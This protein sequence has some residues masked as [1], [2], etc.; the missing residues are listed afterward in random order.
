MKN[1]ILKTK[2]VN[3]T[4][5]TLSDSRQKLNTQTNTKMASNKLTMFLAW[6]V[7]EIMCLCGEPATIIH[8]TK[9]YCCSSC[10]RD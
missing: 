5:H 3:L 9:G 10:A 2:S 6:A 7:Q 8:G 1:G 4:P